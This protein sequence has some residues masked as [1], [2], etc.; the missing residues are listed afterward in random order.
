MDPVRVPQ[1]LELEDIIVLGL[2]AVDLVWLCVGAFIGWWLWLSL[3][4]DIVAR[5]VLAAPPIAVGV[6]FGM[7]RY[8]DQTARGFALSVALY[9]GRPRRRLYEDYPR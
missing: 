7:G 9:L 4:F 5:T 6:L 2:S 8:D 3:P 1:H